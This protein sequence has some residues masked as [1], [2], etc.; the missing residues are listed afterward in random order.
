MVIN[1]T[2]QQH[3]AFAALKRFLENET[4]CFIL[5]GYAGT[6]KTFMIKLLT[7]Y[8][9]EI[10]RSFFL[11]AP[12]G[13][14]ARVIT[15]R[16]GAAASTI[17]S[18]IY[19]L[20][21]MREYKIEDENAS[22]TFRFYFTLKPN[23]SATNAVY[24]I[25]ESSMISDMY[26]DE[27]FARFGSGFLL[28]D[29][30]NYINFD[31]NDHNKKVIFIGDDAQLPPV[32]MNFSPAMDKDY[33]ID[34]HSI[35]VETFELTEVVRHKQ[36]SGII[37]NAIEIR[38]SLEA[39]IF[40]KL[41]I[42][43]DYPDIHKAKNETFIDHYLQACN[44]RI[45]RETIAIAYSNAKVKE[46]NRAIR[47][48]FFPNLDV[49]TAGDR[50]I[51]VR[52][53]SVLL[54]GDFATVLEVS[55]D[56]EL[57]TTNLKK[58]DKEGKL[59]IMPIKLAFRK[60]AI[61]FNGA[62]RRDCLILEELLYSEKRDL[63][64]DENRALYVDFIKRNPRLK[65][66][67]A[68][69]G[70]ALSEDPYFN[71]LRFKFGYAITCH[72]AQGGEWKNVF[73][74]CE[75]KQNLLRKNSY[76]W[77]YTAITRAKETLYVMNAPHI[78]PFDEITVP[79]NKQNTDNSEPIDSNLTQKEDIK[80]SH[81]EFPKPF[82]REFYEKIMEKIASSEIIITDIMHRDYLEKYYFKKADEY[83][84]INFNYNG[85]D[86]F[87]RCLPDSNRC[88]SQPFADY[89]V[90]LVGLKAK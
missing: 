30:L 79:E 7:E 73:I 44:R 56:V 64:S 46:Y 10:R 29:L 33:L 18:L 3:E 51:C 58:K 21:D 8:L 12:T 11:A 28:K 32:G 16:S 15:E 42:S 38:K 2:A 90:A 14:A 25:D 77:L 62:V 47:S 27:E 83:A 49:V 88:S 48:Q 66:N 39:G 45:D 35:S 60:V 22:E 50:L 13:R 81:L 59:Q 63:S 53:G 69:F 89:I 85:K 57:K 70:N 1:L 6:G 75:L 43:T 61:E 23:M 78:T 54:N 86:L 40:N 5:K 84:E 68:E 67:T 19:S 41:N 31:H 20:K 24:I 55:P 4:N 74:D 71:A 87:T 65:R 72:K 80:N 34:K 9:S 26:S 52:N 76:R 82:L 17:H 37:I 36:E